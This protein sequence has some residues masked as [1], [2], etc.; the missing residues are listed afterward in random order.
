LRLRAGENVLELEVA[1]T[2]GALAGR[3]VPTPFGPED[4]RFSGLLER[5]RLFVLDR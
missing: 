3:G 4:Q 5:P 1:N 2:L